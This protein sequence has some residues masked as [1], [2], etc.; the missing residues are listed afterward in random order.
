M[1]IHRR[2]LVGLVA[3]LGLLYA[4]GALVVYH[5]AAGALREGLDAGL[6]ARAREVASHLELA[7]APEHEAEFTRL[8]AAV[9]RDPQGTAAGTRTALERLRRLAHRALQVRFEPFGG[10]PDRD[11]ARFEVLGPDGAR[12]AASPGLDPGALAPPGNGAAAASWDLTL[13]D[14]HA[15][16]ALAWDVDRVPFATPSWRGPWRRLRARLGLPARPVRVRVAADR[17]AQAYLLRGLGTGLLVCGLLVALGSALLASWAVRRGLAPL[18]AL[19]HRLARLDERTL[20]E[21]IDLGTPPA[22]LAPVVGALNAGLERLEEAFERE[23]RLTAHMAH[24]LRTPVAE[25][26]SITDVARTWPEDEALRARCVAQCHDVAEHM[27]RVVEVLLRVARGQ[28]EAAPDRARD[29]ELHAFLAER[30]ERVRAAAATRG[31][32]LDLGV[33]P[34]LGVR[35]DVD[36]LDAIVDNLLRNACEHAPAGSVLRAQARPEDAGVVLVLRN[37]AG[38]VAPADVPRLTDP[39]WRPAGARGASRQG[40]LGLTLVAQLARSARMGFDLA[41][42]EGDF[43][44]RL[45]LPHRGDDGGRAAYSMP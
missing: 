27:G 7:L 10:T 1:S 13:P 34:S 44:A 36:V 29:V 2:L 11:E 33:P 43:R 31:L 21:R 20:P 5:V 15:G 9:L 16:R 3:G 19:G 8:G 30:W 35:A 22:E 32:E 4:G 6:R 26:R 39:F 45:V 23:R 12:L 18:R 40:G 25:L 17:E 41:L 24:E 38:D 37:P 28:G 42:E 14:G